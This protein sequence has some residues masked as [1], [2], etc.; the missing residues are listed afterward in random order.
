MMSPRGG[1]IIYTRIPA[2]LDDADFTRA[3]ALLAAGAG[4]MDKAQLE[5]ERSERL[6]DEVARLLDW[7]DGKTVTVE[8]R[9]R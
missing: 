4:D 8:R 1:R 9:E 6:M 2:L 5:L 7:V 3:R